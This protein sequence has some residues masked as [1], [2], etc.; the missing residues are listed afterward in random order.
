M[1]G[2]D[3]RIHIV[4]AIGPSEKASDLIRMIDVLAEARAEAR[5]ESPTRPDYLFSAK[6]LCVLLDPVKP[7]VYR[8]DMPKARLV[9]QGIAS[10][11]DVETRFRQAI[12][13]HL[14]QAEDLKRAV[15]RGPFEVL[16][17]EAEGTATFEYEH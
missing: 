13:L 17:L 7:N 2:K 15:E 10:D 14:V 16:G 3:F 12:A 11:K 8:A 6:V 4:Q 1:S 5:G 9:F